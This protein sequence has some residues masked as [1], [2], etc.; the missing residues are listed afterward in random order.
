MPDEISHRPDWRGI[1]TSWELARLETRDATAKGWIPAAVPGA[2]QLDWA[3][4]HGWPD[5]NFGQNVRAYDGLEDFHWLYRTR[6]PAAPRTPGEQ[7]VFRCGGVDYACEV[8]LAGRRVL[9]HEG[10]CTPFEV[11]VS[12][13]APGTELEIMILPAPKRH[14][15]PADRT[16]ASHVCK[17]AVSYGWDW[18]PRLIPLG[19]CP[20]TGFVV[21]PSVHLRHVDFAYV[22][23]DD[24]A[25]AEITVTIEASAAGAAATWRLLDGDGRPVVE[26]DSL[27]A[28]LPQPRLWWTH[29][30]GEPAL[31]TLEVTLA[32]GDRF[33]RRVGFRRVRLVKPADSWKQPTGFPISRSEP[34]ITVEL[35]GRT[36]FAK[37]SNWVNPEIFPG[38]IDADTVRPLLQLARAA[39]FNL[40]R[41][42]G[43]AMVGPDA[44]FDQC[45]GLGLL[46][47]QEF[48]L[49]CNNYPDDPAYLR[50][51]DQ[52]SRSIIRRVRPHPC[53]AFWCGGNELFNAWS[54]M[55][56]Q[57]LPL[58]L[59]N[60]NC[61]DLDPGTPFLPT[62]PVEGMGHGDYRF[63]TDQ[64]REIF[65]TF[66]QAANTAYSEFGCPGPSPVAY[67]QSFI[68]AAELWPPRSGSSWQTHHG[69][70]AWDGHPSSW[71]CLEVQEHY[72][73]PPR[74]L[75]EMVARG[76]WLQA[77][78][79]KAVFEEARRQ[80]PRCA[81][82][83]N[84]CYNE[85]WPTAAN[86]S[87]INWPARPK[88]A[89]FAVQAACRPVLA[90]ARFRKFQWTPGELF[91]AEIWL[92][93]DSPAGL[94]GGE[95]E[96]SLVAGARTLTLLRWTIPAVGAGTNLR[97]PTV[98]AA[99]PSGDADAFEL[100]LRA[101]PG[102]WSST[103]RLSLRSAAPSPPS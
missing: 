67:L 58:R 29:D 51:L 12:T 65:E 19:L 25:R 85:P 79:Y 97:G 40:L 42:W 64:G 52:E 68:P 89:Y 45:D 5:L 33:R 72:F 54:G 24:F 86:N 21:R 32:G 61:Y 47:W 59:L 13:C 48:P 80:K 6:V 14:A 101:T 9:E 56:D 78:G 26:S 10:L 2:V 60:R 74:D 7:L 50:I 103:Y 77:E 22:L 83:L 99:L 76:E 44:F 82:A 84:W 98:Q 16:Q 30:H 87:I 81:M 41:C 4:A 63:R 88:P 57:A 49:A 39:H 69:I 1:A 66:Q 92:L 8:R 53:L 70:G 62:A 55:T 96:A 90:S 102:E 100:V 75:A 93:N 37:G 38:R 95:V 11:D 18:H 15:S 23:S 31:Y 28:V 36:I 27:Q 94:P 20:A 91:S 34:P 43:G 17:P 3:R 46:V 35:N 71:L 73:G